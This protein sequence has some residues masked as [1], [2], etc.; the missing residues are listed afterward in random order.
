MTDHEL[1]R[2]QDPTDAALAAA[3]VIERAL[4]ARLASEPR[5][6]LALSGG[7]SPG[8]M[9]TAL[10]DAELP[11]DRVDVFQVDERVAP[12]GDAAR[13]LTGLRA[14]LGEAV[15][16][17]LHPMEVTLGA[18]AAAEAYERTLTEV[19]GPGPRLDVV[20]LGLGDDGHTASLVPGDAACDVTDRD[21][22]T[23]GDYRGHRRVTLTRP[24]IDRAGLVVW[25]VTGED[26]REPLAQLLRGDRSI[27]AGTVSPELSVVVC[28]RAAA[29]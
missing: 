11:W 9:F 1:I 27:P 5:A 29:P 16:G 20:H 3:A 12:D 19:L 28:D 13:N 23:T 7:S 15:R 24:A 18:E 10:F 14:R 21:V 17:R 26:K 25:I 6:S 8:P 2:V 4:R 22:A